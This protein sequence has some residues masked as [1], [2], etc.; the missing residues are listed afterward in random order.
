MTLIRRV[1]GVADPTLPPLAPDF[2]LSGVT[3]YYHPKLWAGASSWLDHPTMLDQQAVPI[4]GDASITQTTENGRPVL[5][6]TTAA[7]ILS[8]AIFDTT[9]VRTLFVVGKVATGDAVSGAGYIAHNGQS[10]INQA[11]LNNPAVTFTNGAPATTAALDKWH[12]FSIASAA[13]AL[14][15]FTIDGSL[16]TATSTSASAPQH[17]R[18][19]TNSSGNHRAMK[20]AGVWTCDTAIAAATITGAVYP[21]VKAWWPEFVWA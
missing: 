4:Q 19:G 13:G 9:E 5:A 15:R 16:F 7:S 6:L 21:L 18:V 17:V 12:L 3:H 11:A 10:G 14:S 8:G 2:G 20:V 1:V